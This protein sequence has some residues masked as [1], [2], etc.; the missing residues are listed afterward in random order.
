[1]AGRDK[2]ERTVGWFLVWVVGATIMSLLGIPALG[3]GLAAGIAATG[4][5]ASRRR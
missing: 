2:L 3:T 5:V 4:W 1:M